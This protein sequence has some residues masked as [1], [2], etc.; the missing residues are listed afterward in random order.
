MVA[1]SLTATVQ[2]KKTI[3]TFEMSAVNTKYVAPD[4]SIFPP[5]P[6]LD[7]QQEGD[8]LRIIQ[9]TYRVL[10]GVN[11]ILGPAITYSEA[12]ISVTY[13]DEWGTLPDGR[14]VPIKGHGNGVYRTWI[15]ITEGPYKGTLEGIALAEWSWDYRVKPY[16]ENWANATLGSGTGGLEGVRMKYTMYAKGATWLYDIRIWGEIIFP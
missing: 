9:G 7:I 6:E 13:F 16:I 12:I 11:P 8:K 3:V 10:E 5:G 4:F 1:T 2:A 14:V 15:E